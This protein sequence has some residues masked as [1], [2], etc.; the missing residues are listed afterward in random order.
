MMCSKMETKE[1]DEEQEECN[2]VPLTKWNEKCCVTRH[3]I[4][5]EDVDKDQVI[6]MP[7]NGSEGTKP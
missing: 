4:S 3:R 2:G 7:K 6:D 1:D 5:K